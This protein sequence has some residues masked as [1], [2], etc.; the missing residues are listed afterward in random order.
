[1]F[2]LYLMINTFGALII[3]LLERYAQG[4]DHEHALA[5]AA[6][7]FIW[8]CFSDIFRQLRIGTSK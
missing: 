5:Y 3:Y 8:S 6:L 4:L 1:M 2:N 7:F